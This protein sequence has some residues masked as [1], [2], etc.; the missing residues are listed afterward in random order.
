M[1]RIFLFAALISTALFGF[2]QA[3]VKAD[4]LVKFKELR[5]NFGK[6]KQGVPVTHDFEFTNVS[7]QPVI[8]ETATASCGCTTPTWPQAP[9]MKEKSASIKAGFNAAAPGPFEKTVYVKVKGIDTPLELRIAGEVVSAA[10]FDK[11]SKK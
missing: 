6:I 3:N 5:H 1:K 11:L 9:V 8:I 10:E 7:G 2:S 4:A